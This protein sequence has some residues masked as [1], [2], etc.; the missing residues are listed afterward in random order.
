MSS[1]EK[2]NKTSFLNDDHF[3]PYMQRHQLLAIR[4]SKQNLME[5]NFDKVMKVSEFDEFED[6]HRKK[7]RKI[8]IS[9]DSQ[10]YAN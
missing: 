10:M 6:V 1:V 8:A 7:I 2:L 4:L 9:Y 3:R 5:M